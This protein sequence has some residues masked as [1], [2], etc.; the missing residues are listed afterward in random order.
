MARQS[1]PVEPP[2]LA[3]AT[4]AAVAGVEM[5]DLQLIEALGGVKLHPHLLRHTVAHQFLAD[6]SNDLVGLAQILGHSCLNT[7]LLDIRS[8]PG[9]WQKLPAG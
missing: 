6:R 7:Q 3:I 8:A 2:G 1:L 4:C 9:S 5:E